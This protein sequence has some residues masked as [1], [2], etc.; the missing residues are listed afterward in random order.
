M[1]IALGP[2]APTCLVDLTPLTADLTLEDHCFQL[3]GGPT[4]PLC[5]TPPR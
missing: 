2:N 5:P 3:K 4:R 1:R